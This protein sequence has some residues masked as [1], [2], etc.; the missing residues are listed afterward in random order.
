MLKYQRMF[1]ANIKLINN[2]TFFI[3]AIV[4][5]FFVA[6]MAMP[7]FNL[8]VLACI[9]CVFAFPIYKWVV[10]KFKINSWVAVTLII[11][12]SLALI[13]IPILIMG[14]KLFN[15]INAFLATLDYGWQ[16]QD[17][18]T[19]V[20]SI[21]EILYSLGLMDYQINRLELV[22]GV[23]DFTTGTWQTIV[24]SLS[25]L[26]FGLV[27]SIFSLVVFGIAVIFMLPNWDTI[28]ST[29]KKLLPLEEQI[30]DMYFRKTKSMTVDV[31]K[32]SLLVAL[33]QGIL[34]F[35][36]FLILG[37]PN[38]LFFSIGIMLLALVPVIGAALVTVPLS[39][40]YVLIGDPLTA[41]LIITWHLLV[42]S[43]ID[44]IIRPFI[45]S[46]DTNVNTAILL[47]AFIAGVKTFGIMGIFYGPIII[48]LFMATL[49]IFQERYQEQTVEFFKTTKKDPS[50]L[51]KKMNM[52]VLSAKNFFKPKVDKKTS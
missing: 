26:I 34:S 37:V 21:N 25:Q 32:G 12:G 14:V 24:N 18:D 27:G 52:Y 28:V 8:L 7:Y 31:I 38:A 40:Y 20:R 47:F 4:L 9:Y 41:I 6:M 3:I 51:Q 15:D 11:I 17:I 45:V 5:G 44:N 2:L 50:K 22:S 36:F 42:I 46:E 39:I 13:V 48:V 30:K 10:N 43:S 29:T 16:D 35:F 33:I 23:K 19:I 1:N 49:Q